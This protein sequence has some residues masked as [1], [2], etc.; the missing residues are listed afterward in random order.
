MFR[1]TKKGCEMETLVGN[2]FGMPILEENEN[3]T[4]PQKGA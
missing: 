2:C 1:E 4:N 3:S